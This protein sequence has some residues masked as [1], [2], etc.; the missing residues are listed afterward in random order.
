MLANIQR[1]GKTKTGLPL[2]LCWRVYWPLKNLQVELSPLQ[3][4]Q[5]SREAL[6]P[7]IWSQPTAWK[8]TK[9]CISV[10]GTRIKSMSRE[11]KVI[12][13]SQIIVLQV[14]SKFL[15][16]QVPSLEWQFSSPNLWVLRKCK[17]IL[18]AEPWL[19]VL[20]ATSIQASN[21]GAFDCHMLIS[22]PWHQL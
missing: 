16:T 3:N 6:E 17:S 22:D 5:A 20:C 12:T 1:Q 19:T 2:A 10:D 7:R 21:V 15:C 14:T 13:T 9:T 18:T 8:H 4:P 11:I